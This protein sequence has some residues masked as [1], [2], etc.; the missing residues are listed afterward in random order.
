MRSLKKEA[1]QKIL[2]NKCIVLGM[3][4]LDE[5]VA[6]LEMPA[7]SI[8]GTSTRGSIPRD[9]SLF[10]LANRTIYTC[11]RSV[12]LELVLA[13]LRYACMNIPSCIGLDQ[14]WLSVPQIRRRSEYQ[15]T[16]HPEPA[17]LDWQ[18]PVKSFHLGLACE[19][20]GIVGRTF[21]VRGF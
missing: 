18:V 3:P 4:A 11:W 14:S 15:I 21:E 8:N 7:T 9:R 19:R 13:R 1:S 20:N 2:V 10:R 17:H 6:L 5:V 12:R 16:H